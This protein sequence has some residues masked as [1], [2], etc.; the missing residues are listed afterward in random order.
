[1]IRSYMMSLFSHPHGIGG[2]LA[3]R[4]MNVF[5]QEMYQSVLKHVSTNQGMILDLVM[6]I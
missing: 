3:T 4:M 1:M 2:K 5:H 6:G